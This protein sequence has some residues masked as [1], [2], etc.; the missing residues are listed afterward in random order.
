MI[1]R[2]M[3]DLMPKYEPELGF[4]VHQPHQLSR[5]VNIAPRN[6]ERVFH[7][8]VQ[9]REPIRSLRIGNPGLDRDA[10]TDAFDIARPGPGFRTTKLGNDLGMLLLCFRDI[11]LPQA[12]GLR[13]C[14]DR[15][16]DHRRGAQQ[17]C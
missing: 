7:R 8:R 4:V 1:G 9:R 10:A 6:G 17:G 15:R 16:H 12:P 3:P 14:S 5:D 13:S 11:R 2:D